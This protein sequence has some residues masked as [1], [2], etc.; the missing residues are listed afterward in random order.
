M[1]I[2]IA[3]V[4]SNNSNYEEFK[5]VWLKNILQ[6]KK[7]PYLSQ[8]Y[9]FYFLYSDSNGES[10]KIMFN[11]VGA[12]KKTLYID[13]YDKQDQ[14]QFESIS[15][16]IFSRTINFFNY[17]ISDLN[18]I[19][20]QLKYKEDGLFFI[21]TNIS[22]VFDFKL[23]L[24]WF[25]NKPKSNFFG[26]S[27]NGFYNGLLTTVSGTNLIFSFDVMMY[28]TFNKHKVNMKFYLE[29]EA[30]SQLIIQ[31]LHVFI[32]NVKRLDF[33][34]MKAVQVRP[35]YLWP[36]TPNSIIYHKTQ[37]GDE[38]IFTFRFKTFN[39]NNDVIVMNYIV[40]ELWKEDFRLNNLVKSV[41]KLYKPELYISEEAPLYGELYSKRPFKIFNLEPEESNELILKIE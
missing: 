14:E 24:K 18:L 15:H 19:E 13:F 4:A 7:D 16:S 22:T 20:H 40:N 37:I 5:N 29:D 27:F 31:E 39:R 6:V 26:G 35:D 8:V 28:L 1:K 9:D 41:S 11:E 36:A 33:I 30:I 21:R 10:K 25:E 12:P 2:I 3:I 17:I 32:I 23:M 38:N 34:E